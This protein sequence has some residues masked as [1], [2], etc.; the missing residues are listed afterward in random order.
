[1]ENSTNPYYYHYKIDFTQYAT[2]LSALAAK[3]AQPNARIDW[4]FPS[5]ESALEQIDITQEPIESLDELYLQRA[6]QLR[7]HYDYLILFYS[8]GNDSNQILETFMLNNIFLDEIMIIERYDSSVESSMTKLEL[9]TAFPE[10][11]ESGKAAIPQ[12][13]FYIETFSPKTKLSVNTNFYQTNRNLWES[14]TDVSLKNHLNSANAGINSRMLPRFVDP[15]YINSDW[16]KLMEVKKVGLIYGK[17]KVSLEQDRTGY[18]IFMNDVHVAEYVDP[19]YFLSPKNL[20]NN[21][22]LFY[23]HPDFV[24][25]HVKQAHQLI[26]QL[27]PHYINDR[28]NPLYYTRALEDIYAKVIYD[29]KYQRLYTGLKTVDLVK[30]RFPTRDKL[31]IKPYEV[32]ELGTELYLKILENDQNSNYH[33]LL[34]EIKLHFLPNV[35]LNK[36]RSLYTRTSCRTKKYYVKYK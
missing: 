18:Y 15:S 30:E 23:S 25:I 1:M 35:Q 12:A 6:I 32:I 28:S 26:H 17:E 29:R 33:K 34:A 13:K 21:T 11:Y 3:Q 24:K 7:N 19:Y 31:D 22:E 8:G 10:F 4:C 36:I 5:W 20:Q 14:F 2:K 9:L 16:I 27:D